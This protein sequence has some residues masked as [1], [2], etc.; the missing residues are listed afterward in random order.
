MLRG[1]C[2]ESGLRFDSQVKQSIPRIFSLLVAWKLE[3][4][5]VYGNRLTQKW[6]KGRRYVLGRA[7]LHAIICRCTSA[8]HSGRQKGLTIK[9]KKTKLN[10]SQDLG[11]LIWQSYKAQHSRAMSMPNLMTVVICKINKKTR[12]MLSY[13]SYEVHKFIIPMRRHF[14]QSNR[15]KFHLNCLNLSSNMSWKSYY[16]H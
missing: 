6:W 11:Q 4:Y 16:E 9:V 13:F 7:A 1:D 12:K 10:R 8:F 15:K 5:P 3:L 2:R 14:I